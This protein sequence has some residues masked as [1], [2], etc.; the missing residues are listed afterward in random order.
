MT[1]L[2]SLT[3]EYLWW[4]GFLLRTN[5][6]VGKL[7]AGGWEGELDIVGYHPKER[8]VVH[9]ETSLDALSWP[10]REKKYA[11]KF[12]TGRR[13]I[14]KVVFPWLKDSGL[15]VES[16]AVLPN[17]PKD[18]RTEIGGGRL[19]TVDELVRDIR[20]H[21]SI[22]PVFGEAIPESYPLLRTIQMTEAG[23]KKRM[24]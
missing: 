6:W 17:R 23:Y 1:H 5:I 4:R 20:H 24:K 13:H 16:V 14:F 21:V 19:V 11:K 9:Y 22:H 15:P 2:E 12:D 3:A 7:S 8:R 10:R 18:G